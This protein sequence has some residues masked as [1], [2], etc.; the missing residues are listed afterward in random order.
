MA[1]VVVLSG[2]SSISVDES[3]KKRTLYR[4]RTDIQN[5]T[6]CYTDKKS[7]T[8]T[9]NTIPITV[10]TV[11]AE[12]AVAK[13]STG[14]DCY[15]ILNGR[16][17][18]EL[19]AAFDKSLADILG[20]KCSRRI[21]VLSSPGGRVRDAMAIGGKIRSNDIDTLFDGVKGRGNRCASSC[22][23]IFIAG[24]NRI[25]TENPIGLLSSNMGF[26]QWSRGIG[27]EKTCTN[28]DTIRRGLQSYAT[29]MLPPAAADQFIEMTIKTEC[30]KMENFSPEELIGL[31]IATRKEL[32]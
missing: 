19:T 32:Q 7:K 13:A 22:T 11:L 12:V 23:L 2:C 15:L 31:G 29:R 8:R 1:L 18:E 6:S 20:M 3:T 10:T 21:A 30:K 24:R 27:T 5:T 14:D 4:D 26:H 16:I 25:V 9:C 17:D 28:P